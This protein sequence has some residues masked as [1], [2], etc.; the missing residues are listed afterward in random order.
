MKTNSD[1]KLR[2]INDLE[3]TLKQHKKHIQSGLIKHGF[4]ITIDQWQV[5]DIIVNNKDIKQTEIA[6]KTS[7]D[8]ASITRII[9]LLNR[10]GY[11]ARQ[12]DPNNRR[13]LVLGISNH[14]EKEYIKAGEVI[15]ELTNNALGGLKEKRMKKLK[16]VFKNIAKNCG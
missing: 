16:K 2:F 4:D 5:L 9:E 11:V 15:A 14:G 13:R 7:K 8:A 12:T 6:E 10:K 1:L 3:Y